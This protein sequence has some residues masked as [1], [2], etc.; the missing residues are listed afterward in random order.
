[1]DVVEV[2]VQDFVLI[3]SWMTKIFKDKHTSSQYYDI[4]VIQITGN[5]HVFFEPFF[6]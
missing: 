3:D 1:M 6:A 5:H 2:I 4:L